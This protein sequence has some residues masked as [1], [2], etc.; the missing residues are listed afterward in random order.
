MIRVR[1]TALT[2]LVLCLVAL[3][4]RA[5]PDY[6]AINTAIAEEVMIPAY[7][8]LAEATQAHAEDWRKACA[9]EGVGRDTL[10]TSYHTV[11]DAWAESFHWNFGPVTLLLRRDRFY[12]WPER[13]NAVLKSLNKLFADET[14]EKLELQNFAHISVAAQGLP[15]MERMLFE[16]TDT[17]D[18]SWNCKVAQTIAANMEEMAGGIV[19]EWRDDVLPVMKRGEEH[20]I[21]FSGP[22][23]TLNKTFTDLLTGYAIIKDQKILPVMGSSAQKAKPALVEARRSN[24][25]ARNLKHNLQTLFA[26]DAIMARYLP[27]AEARD[28]AQKREAVMA[29]ALVLPDFGE[30]VYDQQGRAQYKAFVD[31][32]SSLRTDMF[33]AYTK[34]LGVV[35]GFNSLDG[36]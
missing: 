27:E 25:F 19:K 30:A 21:Y 3:P 28:L 5:E 15:A 26:T 18:K 16:H 23:E 20:P 10:K 32:L 9:G 2:I 29:Q 8:R 35:V 6:V 12:H 36:D 11:A 31:A 24:R 7:A 22:K 34:H 14:P 4:A 33:S 1:H 13:R 17:L